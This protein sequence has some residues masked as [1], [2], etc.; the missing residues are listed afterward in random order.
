MNKITWNLVKW[1]GACH[2]FVPYRRKWGLEF[3]EGQ[4]W[5]VT[6]R[7]IWGLEFDEGQWAPECCDACSLKVR[8]HCLMWGRDPKI[9][10]WLRDKTAPQVEENVQRRLTYVA[11]H[12]GNKWDVSP[13]LASP[14]YKTERVRCHG[15]TCTG[16]GAASSHHWVLLLEAG[17]TRVVR[18]H[19]VLSTKL[20][21]RHKMANTETFL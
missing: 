5:L 6:Y 21:Q 1:L 4:Y 10:A 14:V 16:T 19:F 12:W 17:N 13:T 3:D 20:Y 8:G 9:P 11:E 18:H 15:S 7:H 2:W